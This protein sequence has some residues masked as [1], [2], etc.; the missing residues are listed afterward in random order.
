MIECWSSMQEAL[1]PIPKYKPDMGVYSLQRVG[2]AGSEVRVI[3]G[4]IVNSSLCYMRL[5]LKSSNNK[6]F[7]CF[8]FKR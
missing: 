6:V 8:S 1:S 2:A 4:Y 3:L 7:L 5:C